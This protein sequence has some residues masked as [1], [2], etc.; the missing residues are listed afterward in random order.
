MI[1]HS[2]EINAIK[3]QLYQYNAKKKNLG[4]NEFER[5][6]YEINRISACKNNASFGRG[7]EAFDSISHYEINLIHLS[8]SSVLENVYTV[9]DKYI[10]YKFIRCLSSLSPFTR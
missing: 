1:N 8:S 9:K 6:S 10:Y 5:F 7:R 4:A 2:G 3:H